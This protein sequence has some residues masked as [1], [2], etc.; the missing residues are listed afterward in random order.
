MTSQHTIQQQHLHIEFNGVESDAWLLQ[1]RLSG[2]CQDDLLPTLEKVFNRFADSESWSIDRLDIDAGALTLEHWE[3]NLTAV[4]AEAIEKK[5]REQLTRSPSVSTDNIRHKTSQQSLAEALIYFLNTGRLPWSI[6]LTK[7]KS[8]EQTLLDAWQDGVATIPKGLIL[9][10][11]NAPTARKRLV[12]QFLPLF[13]TTL[14][15]NFSLE[16]KKIITAILSVQQN[17]DTAVKQFEQ[18]LWETLFAFIATGKTLSETAIITEAWQT[19]NLSNSQQ[20]TLENALLDTHP[21]IIH[22]LLASET[23]RKRLVS[24]FSPSLMTNLVTQLSPE[25]QKVIVAI[26]VLL[27]NS[28]APPVVVKQFE[29]QLWETVFT[30]IATGKTVTENAVIAEAWQALV[31]KTAALENLLARHWSAAITSTHSPKLK[32]LSSAPIIQPSDSTNKLTIDHEQENLPMTD[33]VKPFK[34]TDTNESLDL[35]KKLPTTKTAFQA[36]DIKG[37]IYIENSGLILLHPF[38]PQ[39]FTALGVAEEDQ[40]IQPERALCLLH[41][42]TTGVRIAPEY[43]LT[44]SKIL[45][46]IPL[47]TPV[48]SDMELSDS[49]IEEAEALLNAVIRHWDALRNTSIDGLRGEF[50]LRFG[51]LSVRDDGDWLLQVENKTVDILLNQLPWGIS[52]IKL[53]WTQRML[54]VEWNY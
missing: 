50:L 2:W 43:E 29:Q 1:N 23:T 19:L 38:L 40:L 31:V 4:V 5:L 45:C 17:P 51:K 52:M 21:V 32:P 22:T 24:Q 26:L 41:F 46:N 53:P 15:D 7:N 47:D 33:S 36:A 20:H 25:S 3:Q 11:L 54:W 49:E 28:D 10:T 8:F 16:G 39:F 27:Q 34:Q 18:Q 42:L 30:F 37:G 48:E 14:L 6:T 9:S 13:M 12:R 44:L 35:Q